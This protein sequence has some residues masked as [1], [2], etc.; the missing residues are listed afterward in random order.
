MPITSRGNKYVVVFMD[1]FMKWVEAFA[2]PDQEASTIA[3][4]LVDNIVVVTEY[5]NT[6]FPIVEPISYRT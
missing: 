3:R 1:Y 4:L 5:H 6:Y 2:V